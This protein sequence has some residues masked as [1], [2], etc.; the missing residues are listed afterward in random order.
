MN[1]GCCL[2]LQET[3]SMHLQTKSV[4]SFYDGLYHT[5]GSGTAC[6]VYNLH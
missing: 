4:G 3:M 6:D 5:F 2:I 1:S